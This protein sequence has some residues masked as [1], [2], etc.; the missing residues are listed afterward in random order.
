MH[1]LAV[2]E[3]H[4]VNVRVSK[5]VNVDDMW[6]D[7]TNIVLSEMTAERY[8]FETKSPLSP[9]GRLV[10]KA[11]MTGRRTTRTTTDTRGRVCRAYEVSTVRRHARALQVLQMMVDNCCCESL[12]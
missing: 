2:Q 8:T 3:L 9:T 11:V 6:T 5:Q 1:R 4:R 7:L 12:G 10:L